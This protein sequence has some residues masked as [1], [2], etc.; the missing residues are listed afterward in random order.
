PRYNL[1]RGIA[2]KYKGVADDMNSSEKCH[3]TSSEKLN[4]AESP[5]I[6]KFSKTVRFINAIKPNKLRGPVA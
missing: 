6:I 4:T 3:T 5:M 1:H 2:S